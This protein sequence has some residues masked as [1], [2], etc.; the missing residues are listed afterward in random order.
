MPGAKLCL[1]AWRP[2]LSILSD[3]LIA[4]AWGAEQQDHEHQAQGRA[5]MSLWKGPE[6]MPTPH[7]DSRAASTRRSTDV[8]TAASM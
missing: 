1:L 2:F 4:A 8:Y 5:T 3:L 6:L 7:D